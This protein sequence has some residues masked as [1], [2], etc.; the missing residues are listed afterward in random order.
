[1]SAISGLLSTN[2]AATNELVGEFQ[3]TIFVRNS[4]GFNVG[5]TL[6]GLMSRLD[7][8]GAENLEYNWFERDPVRK[9]VYAQ[10]TATSS[11]TALTFSDT[12]T[13]AAG[14]V[15][16]LLHA[17]MVL[18]NDVSREYVKVTA[19]PTDT[20]NTITV[21]RGFAGTAAT[22][23]AG[24]TFTIV[25]LGKGEG[26][27]PV[28]AAY[29]N[30][31]TLTNYIQTFNSVVE[32]TNAFKG[33]VLR[34]DIE[35]P[36]NDRR[37]QALEK[38][39]RDIEFSYLLGAKKKTASTSN[40]GFEYFT[41]GVYQGL[42]DAGLTSNVQNGASI[43]LA[44]FNAWLSN[45]LPY[46]SDV[47]LAFAG[48]QAYSAISTFANTGTNGY[49]IM[50]NETVFGMH[51]QVINTPF[52][53]LNLAQHPLLREAVGL[54]DWMFVL[55]LPHLTQKVFE[56]L[57]LEDNIQNNGVDSYKEQ[58]RAKLGLRMKFPNAFGVIY[59]LASIT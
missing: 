30:P 21:T 40:A 28:R 20:T 4:R 43:T 6:F 23:N 27:D 57:F 24:D 13:G 42:I 17:G 8:E 26:S 31:S 19:T 35:G 7:N 1:M 59:D 36:L 32:L 25:T 58:F 16:F 53:E 37:L 3:E 10:A 55:D 47:K 9:T 39:S 22:I 46:G 56:K 5:S 52:G 33:S 15:N 41:G 38:I 45:V 50:Q 44:N 14:T 34:T 2:E 12:A 49:R 29:E 18:M 54:R 11:I 51:I 48:P